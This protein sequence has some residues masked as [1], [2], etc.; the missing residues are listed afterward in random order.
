MKHFVICEYHIG[1]D[2][3]EDAEETLAH[4]KDLL[5]SYGQATTQD[6]KDYI[7][8]VPDH[9]SDKF[10]WRNLDDAG[11]KTYPEDP[12]CAYYLVLPDPAPLN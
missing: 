10:G 4:L 3:R 11:I 2:F 5:K 6:L 9:R 12:N 1:F 7:G 8:A